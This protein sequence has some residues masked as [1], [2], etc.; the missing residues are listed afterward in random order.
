[1]VT[2]NFCSGQEQGVE[3]A[4]AGKNATEGKSNYYDT[5]GDLVHRD[6]ILKE[7]IGKLVIPDCKQNGVVE[8]ARTSIVNSHGGACFLSLDSEAETSETLTELDIL[9]SVKY[10]NNTAMNCD[11]DVVDGNDYDAE[12]N[13]PSYDE[14]LKSFETTQR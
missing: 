11:K 1:M 6:D 12:I 8:V 10:K 5:D 3:L 7:S 14:M 13:K 4:L 9:D 2:D